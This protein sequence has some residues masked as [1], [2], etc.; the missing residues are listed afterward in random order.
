MYIL[1]RGQKNYNPKS[2]DTTLEVEESK[3]NNR[4]VR[5][6]VNRLFYEKSVIKTKDF[7]KRVIKVTL[8]GFYLH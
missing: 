2:F 5:K 3:R 4:D 8:S 6:F 1:T 7:N